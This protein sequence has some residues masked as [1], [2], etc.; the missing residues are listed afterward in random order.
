MDEEAVDQPVTAEEWLAV[1]RENIRVEDPHREITDESQ[2]ADAAEQRARDTRDAETAP[3][4]NAEIMTDEPHESEPALETDV[5]DV[6]EIA[7]PEPQ[8]A[9]E[10]IVRTPSVG[11]TTDTIGRA[12]RALAEVGR[13]CAAEEQHAAEEEARTEQLA[14]WHAE[15]VE[16]E[17]PKEAVGQAG[18]T[19]DMA[20]TEKY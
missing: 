16:H 3:T 10:N 12:Q 2:L 7:A 4:R 6:R 1:Q 18:P 19:L 15:D 9:D 11:E 14:R 13:R 5:P 8:P 17:A 20:R